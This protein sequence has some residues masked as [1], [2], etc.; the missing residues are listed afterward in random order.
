MS[1]DAY[2]FSHDSNARN[3]IKITAMRSVYGCKGYGWYWIIV[4]VLRDEKE[5]R[6]KLNE[7]TFNALAMQMQ[8]KGNATKIFIEN[9]INDYEL[10]SS[11]GEYFWSNSLLKRMKMIE[12]TSLKRRNAALLRWGDANAMQMQCNSNAM[13]GNEMKGNE[14]KVLK[15]VCRFTP[16]T[17]EEV[18]S[19]CVE[20]KNK[21]DAERFIDFYTSKGWKIGKNPMKD[22]KAAV[23]T[24]EKE[25]EPQIVK[26]GTPQKN[27]FDQ[28]KY[29]DKFF[30]ELDGASNG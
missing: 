26:Q 3:D 25:R 22:W 18:K 5:H 17:L 4:E 12:S 30:A 1:K 9:C 23:R 8:C 7:N 14:M 29:D 27:N 19:Y 2:Y 21:V 28:R 15:E 13:K 20:R 10:F 11:D 6:L 24:W 16:P